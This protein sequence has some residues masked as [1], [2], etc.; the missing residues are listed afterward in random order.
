MW[1]IESEIAISWNQK[2]LPTE[3]LEHHSNYKNLDPQFLLPKICTGVKNAAEIEGKA[4]Q[5]QPQHKN[6]CTKDNLVIC[7]YTCRQ[8]VSIT[9]ICVRCRDPELNTKQSLRTITEEWEEGLE[10]LRSRT[11]QENSRNKLPGPI[12]GSQKLNHQP[13]NMH[14]MDLVPLRMCNKFAGRSSCGVHIRGKRAISAF[15]SLS[16]N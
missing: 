16:S 7:W 6:H 11:P 2:R 12:G 1:G 13:E 10:S 9:V 5:W 4:N 8:G 3:G 15:K 14:R